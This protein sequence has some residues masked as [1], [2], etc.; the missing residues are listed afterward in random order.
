MFPRGPHQHLD[1][2]SNSTALTRFV[3][4]ITEIYDVNLFSNFR[5]DSDFNQRPTT[6]TKTDYIDY[7]DYAD[8]TDYIDC[9]TKTDYTDYIDY[10]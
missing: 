5:A 2:S 10:G 7:I 6:P 3:A 9:M 1:I 4:L 8:Y